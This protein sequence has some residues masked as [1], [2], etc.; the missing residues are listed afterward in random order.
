MILRGV[1]I[2]GLDGGMSRKLSP[3]SIP[4]LVRI[5]HAK[6]DKHAGDID[7]QDEL[8]WRIAWNCVTPEKPRSET[9]NRTVD[10]LK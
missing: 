1:W 5:R 9:G 8:D 4:H 3:R 7:G 10:H 2:F 6:M